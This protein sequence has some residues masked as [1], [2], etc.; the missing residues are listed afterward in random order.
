MITSTNFK[1]LE[2]LEPANFDD[3]EFAEQSIIEN[4]DASL[5]LD[6][7]ELVVVY[8]E[9]DTEAEAEVSNYF[10]HMLK[11]LQIFFFLATSPNCSKY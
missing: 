2:I 4:P 9:E 6:D 8:T 11:L 10:V 7:N 3:I 5:G 1:I